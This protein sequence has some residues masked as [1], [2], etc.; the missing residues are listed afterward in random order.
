M[1]LAENYLH[2]FFTCM[3][4][5]FSVKNCFVYLLYKHFLDR[6][7]CLRCFADKFIIRICSTLI[8]SCL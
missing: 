2:I 5:K 4:E 6:S 3:F 7:T 8:L 1:P